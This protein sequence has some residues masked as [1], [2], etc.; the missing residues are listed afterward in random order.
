VN[1]FSQSILLAAI[2]ARQEAGDSVQVRGVYKVTQGHRVDIVE[3]LPGDFCSPLE[4]RVYP[5]H[6]VVLPTISFPIEF[7]ASQV[8]RIP[9][10]I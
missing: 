8:E 4:K 3:R 7:A 9:C 1:W 6:V 2:G 5:F 10:G